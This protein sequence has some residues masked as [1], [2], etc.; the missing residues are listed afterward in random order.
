MVIA[1][2]ILMGIAYTLLGLWK[3]DAMS[4]PT[5]GMEGLHQQLRMR[6]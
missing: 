4:S 3:K 2:A 1:L 5:I 6:E